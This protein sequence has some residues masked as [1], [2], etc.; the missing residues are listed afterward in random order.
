M[1]VNRPQIKNQSQNFNFVF[2]KRSEYKLIFNKFLAWLTGFVKVI[3]T[4]GFV[5]TYLIFQCNV[6]EPYGINFNF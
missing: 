4:S 3:S 6:I 5:K 1:F 2:K